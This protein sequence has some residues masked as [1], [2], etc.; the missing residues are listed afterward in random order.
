MQAKVAWFDRDQPL[1][2]QFKTGVS[3]HSHTSR[4]KESLEFVGR[5]FESHPLLRAFI[6]IAGGRGRQARYYI[7]ISHKAIGLHHCARALPMK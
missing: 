6:R 5:I 7:S 2:R 3:I 1:I 4:S